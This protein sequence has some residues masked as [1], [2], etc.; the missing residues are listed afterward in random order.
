MGFRVLV[1][2]ENAMDAYR[3]ACVHIEL[4]LVFFE[5]LLT[6]ERQMGG[7]FRRRLCMGLQDGLFVI[8]LFLGDKSGIK[9]RDGTEISELHEWAVIQRHVRNTGLVMDV[10]GAL[11][12]QEPGEGAFKFG[13]GK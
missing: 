6:A 10:A 2:F 9:F 4:R 1:P 12:L 8:G 11:I 5:D 7:I 13:N 3:R